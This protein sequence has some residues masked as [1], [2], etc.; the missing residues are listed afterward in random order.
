[1]IYLELFISFFKIGLFSYGGG[2]AMI[3][4]ISSEIVKHQWLA[5]AEFIKIIGIAQMTPGPIAVNAATFVGYS[6][7]GLLGALVSTLGVA[8]PSVLIIMLISK[9]FFEHNQHPLVKSIF[10]YI[11]PIIAGLVFASAIMIAR[12]TII[13]KAN[14]LDEMPYFQVE[15]ILIMLV[16]L[17]IY[18]KKKLHPIILITIAGLLGYMT[19]LI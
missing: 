5:E 15:T 2:Y 14:S 12:T 16:I 6:T 19:M 10:K 3:P 17:V 13:V 8:M 11:R 18:L 9:L 4:L 1:M 7:A